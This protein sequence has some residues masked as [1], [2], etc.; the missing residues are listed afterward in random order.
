MSIPFSTDEAHYFASEYIKRKE[1]PTNR[2]FFTTYYVVVGLGKDNGVLTPF[3]ES[4]FPYPLYVG[5][6]S[7]ARSF[8]YKRNNC[9]S[10]YLLVVNKDLNT[11]IIFHPR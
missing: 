3:A 10:E 1:I 4:L 2:G 11:K 5:S 8:F 7:D 6:E 9:F